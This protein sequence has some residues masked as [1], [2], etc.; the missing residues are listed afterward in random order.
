MAY[1]QVTTTTGSRDEGERIG[2]ALVGRRLAACFQV[3]GPIRSVYWWHGEIETADEWLCLV[4]TT[5]ERFDQLAESLTELHSYEV[6]EIVATEIV[7]GGAS[8]L[9][10]ISEETSDV[11]GRGQEGS[12][13]R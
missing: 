5:S 8:Y 10:W 6:P 2:R 3:V 13:G 4:K 9:E 7:R 12:S 11:A 1:L